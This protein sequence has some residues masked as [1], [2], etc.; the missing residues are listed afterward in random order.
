V[1]RRGR[2]TTTHV[3]LIPATVTRLPVPDLSAGSNEPTNHRLKARIVLAD[4]RA[5]LAEFET[6][7]DA[8]TRRLRW[9]ALVT[10]LRAV[11]HVLDGI[12]KF[13]GDDRLRHAIDN[14]FKTRRDQPI[15]SNF[16]TAER[17]SVL[18]EYNF[19]PH[20]S[21]QVV[22]V[23][24]KPTTETDE[25]GADA[26]LMYRLESATVLGGGHF[27]GFELVHLARKAIEFWVEY[28]NAVE[29]AAESR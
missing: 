12:D 1:H 23:Y 5:A 28:L 2:H 24:A 27:Q 29:T 8:N 9:V 25:S 15:F 3:V 13:S 14:E 21:V 19:T 11:G 16:I 22:A 6:A 20:V 7:S 26:P 4:C 17:N 10:L 18:K